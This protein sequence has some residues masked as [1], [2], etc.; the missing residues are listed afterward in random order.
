[1]LPLYWQHESRGENERWVG[2]WATLA[3]DFGNDSVASY[4][5][6]KWRQHRNF[7]ATYFVIPASQAKPG[8]M[9]LFMCFMYISV[10]S[11]AQI[12]RRANNFWHVISQVA[13]SPRR[14]FWFAH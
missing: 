2:R 9:T 5:G 1:M 6:P 7:L 14:L 3:Q 11:P 8:Q 13:L 10:I 12:T 4:T